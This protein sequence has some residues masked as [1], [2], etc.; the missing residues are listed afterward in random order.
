MK[1]QG[2]FQDVWRRLTKTCKCSGPTI[3]VGVCFPVLSTVGRR[4]QGLFET[5]R[6]FVGGC[7]CSCILSRADNVFSVN[8]R[9]RGPARPV[10]SQIRRNLD[11]ND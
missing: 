3:S 1:R 11:A 7:F 4:W 5:L 9:N 2:G 8:V 6:L 10:M